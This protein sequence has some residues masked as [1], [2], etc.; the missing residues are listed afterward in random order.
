MGVYL[1]KFRSTIP[2]TQA[3]QIM[4]ILQQEHRTGKIN[5][6]E[7]FKNRLKTLITELQEQVIRPTL[8]LFLAEYG[9]RIDSESFNS[10]LERITD[11]LNTAFIEAG[12]VDEILTLHNSLIMDAIYRSMHIALDNLDNKISSFELISNDD[13]GWDAAFTGVLGGSSFKGTSRKDSNASILFSDPIKGGSIDVDQD[14]SLDQ[15]GPRILLGPDVEQNISIAHIRS[16]FDN[17]S[18]QSELQVSVPDSKDI[19]NII[20]GKIGTFWQNSFLTKAIQSNGLVFKLEL[21]LGG[22]RTFN[23]LI[24]E[25]ASFHP[26]VLEKIHILEADGSTKT[27][28][29]A[30]QGL[31]LN[32]RQSLFIA[33]TITSLVTL[34][35]RQKNY[36]EVQFTKKTGREFFVHRGDE[37]LSVNLD[38]I[39]VDLQNILS[40]SFLK[41]EVI[42]LDPDDKGEREQLRFYEYQVGFDNIRVQFTTF[43]TRSIYVDQKTTALKPGIIGIKV[44]ESRP[45]K[46]DNS[47]AYT[48]DVFPVG[49]TS[50]VILGAPPSVLPGKW[51][52]ATGTSNKYLCNVEYWLHKLDFGASG[53]LL[54][55][56]T[57]PLLPINTNIVMH[58]RFLP[59]RSPVNGV[60]TVGKLRFWVKTP[61]PLAKVTLLSSDDFTTKNSQLRKHIRVYKNGTEIPPKDE[62]TTSEHGWY[63]DTGYTNNTFANGTI[64]RTGIR[65]DPGL[66]TDI[67]TVSYVPTKSNTLSVPIT[68]PASEYR[69]VDMIGDGSMILGNNNALV[70]LKHT[71]NG[72]EI[73]KSDLYVSIILRRNSPENHISAAIE[74]LSLLTGKRDRSKFDT[75]DNF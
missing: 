50:P 59:T 46:P 7:E 27:T 44:K 30:N 62:F 2:A 66:L 56:R 54:Q 18:G 9:L 45:Y 43:D 12:N 36:Q 70:A 11:D 49:D 15:V 20:D 39:S 68:S 69:L 55:N 37:I 5:S 19:N 6:F 16:V 13:F 51:S 40:S 48:T 42:G 21:D 26:M 25:P 34:E 73:D 41:E 72:E 67:Y 29:L 24:F 75:G 32:T 31:I 52:E 3:R 63:L 38:D 22:R 14:A 8:K 10:M 35:F 74:S 17:I 4:R 1:D 58:E 23:R 57:I 61:T 71:V 33:P 60:N 53:R 28:T 47:I 65:V 64:M